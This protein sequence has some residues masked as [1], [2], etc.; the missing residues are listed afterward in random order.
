MM[1]VTV[2]LRVLG[3]LYFMAVRTRSKLVRYQA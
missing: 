3:L 2:W 1:T